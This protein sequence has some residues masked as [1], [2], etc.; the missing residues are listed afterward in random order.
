MANEP[1]P[2]HNWPKLCLHIGRPLCVVCC[3][4]CSKIAMGMP[5]VLPDPAVRGRVISC[6]E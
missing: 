6:A 2:I 5:A 3:S 4:S 1:H